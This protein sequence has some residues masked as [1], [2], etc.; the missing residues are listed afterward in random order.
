M[1]PSSTHDTAAA[2][3]PVPAAIDLA[4][5]FS[6]IETLWQ[7]RVVAE[8]NDYQFKLARIDGDFIW[9]QHDGT[10]EAFIV[11][12]GHLRIDLPDTAVHLRA[13]DMLV[14]PG[15]TP[16]R[17]SAQGEVWLMLVEPRGVANTGDA[18][19]EGMAPDDIRA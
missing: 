7:P 3:K 13:G 16:H 18:G 19:G 11:V 2:P 4:H 17:P 10:D 6:L 9:H 15:G 1:I 14:V 5:K 8:M 12:R